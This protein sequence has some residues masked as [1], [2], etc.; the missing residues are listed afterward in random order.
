MYALLFDLFFV[1]YIM[2]VRSLYTVN[3]IF[4]LFFSNS[5]GLLELKL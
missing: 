4:G 3:E 1:L 2:S 5:F